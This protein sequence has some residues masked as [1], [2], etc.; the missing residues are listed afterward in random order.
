MEHMLSLF[1]RS[2]FVDNMIFAFFLGVYP[3]HSRDCRYRAIGG[4]GGGTFF[5]FA[6]CRVGYIPP[7]DCRELRHHGCLTVHAAENLH[8]SGHE[9]AGYLQR[10]GFF[11]IRFGFR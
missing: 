3:F 2:I 4:D 9:H 1:V 11:G 8:G 6:L 5:S 7:F 10:M